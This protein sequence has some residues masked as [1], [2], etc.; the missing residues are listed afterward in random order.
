MV[1]ADIFEE[2]DFATSTTKVSKAVEEARRRGRALPVD[3]SVEDARLQAH[4]LLRRSLAEAVAR[5]AAERHALQDD[6]GA[7]DQPAL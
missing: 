4:V 6:G 5:L 1:A 2:E 7:T 3:E